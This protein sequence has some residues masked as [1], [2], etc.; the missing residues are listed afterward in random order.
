M[1]NIFSALKVDQVVTL[2]IVSNEYH[3]CREGMMKLISRI[4]SEARGDLSRLKL[5]RLLPPQV[6]YSFVCNN[7]TEANESYELNH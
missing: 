6:G 5:S 4:A 2:L 7:L 3:L 1:E